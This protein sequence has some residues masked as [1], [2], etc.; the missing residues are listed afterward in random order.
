MSDEE[1]ARAVRDSGNCAMEIDAAL[2]LYGCHLD[3]DARGT[4][5]AVRNIALEFGGGRSVHKLTNT[6][7]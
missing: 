5:I 7:F 6:P 2:K 3:I 1:L 4:A